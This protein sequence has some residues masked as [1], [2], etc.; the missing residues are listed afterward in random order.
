MEECIEEDEQQS[1][2]SPGTVRDEETLAR[3]IWR[4]D[5]LAEDGELAPAAFPVQD[6]LDLSRGGLS[7]ARLDHMTA[8]EIRRHAA[9]VGDGNAT[10][11]RGRAVAET[12]DIRAIRANDARV[13][14]VLDDGQPDFPAHAATRLADMR[15]VSRSS[16]RRVR[17]LLMR[18]FSYQ[19]SE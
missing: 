1:S 8:V 14:C 9:L 16:A 17:N 19:S 10:T 2:H 6:F 4:S 11:A 7:V 3:F 12:K 5:H 13:F 15:G 18:V